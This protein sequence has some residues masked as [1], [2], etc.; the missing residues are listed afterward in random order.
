M[1]LCGMRW[2]GVPP[3]QSGLVLLAKVV[4]EV[5]Q[6]LVFLDYV[7]FRQS[8]KGLCLFSPN[9]Q[10]KLVYRIQC[11]GRVCGEPGVKV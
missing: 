5:E 10:H 4:V 6:S 3:G 11:R 2:V 7:H 8:V 1:V 9:Q